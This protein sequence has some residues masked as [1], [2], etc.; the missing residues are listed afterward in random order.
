VIGVL[1]VGVLV[2]GALVIGYRWF[3]Y[4]WFGYRLAVVWLSVGS[5]LVVGRVIK[6]VRYGE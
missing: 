1:V 2:I 6:L 5:G 4:R 3:G